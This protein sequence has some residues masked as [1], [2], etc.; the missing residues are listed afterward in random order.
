MKVVVSSEGTNKESILELEKNNKLTS[1]FYDRF[2][3]REKNIDKAV[4][5]EE[6]R[7]KVLS[8]Y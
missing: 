8:I 1:G 3:E 2:I 4:D 7:D 6:K 5:V